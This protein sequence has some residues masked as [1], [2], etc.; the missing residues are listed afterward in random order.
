[1]SSVSPPGRCAAKVFRRAPARRMLLLTLLLAGG[2]AP[3]IVGRPAYP[4]IR[5]GQDVNAELP[6]EGPSL[7]F[8]GVFHAYE[9]DAV[10]GNR[11]DIAVRSSDF[12]PYVRVGQ[13]VNGITDFLLDDDDSGEG[14]D[15]LASFSPPAAGRY[16][17]IVQAVGSRRG[18]Y[19]LGITEAV[20]EGDAPED[21]GTGLSRATQVP[22]GV[23]TIE[24]GDTIRGTL[25]GAAFYNLRA[26]AGQSLLLELSSA[27]FD[28]YLA[29][30]RTANGEFEQIAYDDDAGE[31]TDSRLRF[32]VPADG[33][34]TIRVTAFSSGDGDYTLVA[35]TR[36]RPARM[37][38]G[39]LQ[40]GVAV[41]G[42]LTDD[43]P[44]LDSLY[45]HDEWLLDATANARYVVN[46][47]SEEFDTYLVVGR[48][49][50]SG[51]VELGRDDDSGDGT[52]S[53]LAFNAPET[54]EYVIRARPFS[55]GRGAYTL[56][57]EERSAAR[58]EP[59]VRRTRLGEEVSGALTEMDARLAD[60]SVYQHWLFSA[61]RGERVVISLNS[62][63]FDAF[64]A[65]GVI[66]DGKTFIEYTSNDDAD[67]QTRNAR[68]VLLAPATREYV[69][70]VNTF[71]DESGAYTLQLERAR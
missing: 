28:T 3:A 25:R 8:R 41:N 42:E 1:M 58:L 46:L 66:N 15:A 51:F 19:T 36:E 71:G 44:V 6:G 31:G 39:R 43:S 70:R 14:T 56:L 17:V 52:N 68:V 18:A 65:V 33:E 26:T 60:G 23:P 7:G 22:P 13:S 49:T 27:D 30:G 11:Y 29:I 21:V 62:S 45:P 9:F 35:S 57:V 47:G 34:Y 32:T 16:I 50:G 20:G 24:T 38:P 59:V 63:E 5:P 2:C 69:I 40:P 10:A 4:V 67:A 48:N 12:D 37:E 54:G 64:L 61:R 53:R 55:S